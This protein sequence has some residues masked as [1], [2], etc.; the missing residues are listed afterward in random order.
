[1]GKIETPMSDETKLSSTL[2]LAARIAQEIAT[3]STDVH[4][5]ARKAL[6]APRRSAC[7]APS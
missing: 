6:R 4:Y 2:Q 7:E 5:R 1:M 3:R